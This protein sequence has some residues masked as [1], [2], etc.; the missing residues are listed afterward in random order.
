M[1]RGT[2]AFKVAESPDDFKLAAEEFKKASDV[3]PWWPEAYFNLGLVKEQQKEYEKAIFDLKLYLLAAPQGPD[4][5]S[6]KQK[7][8]EME[9]LADREKTKSSEAQGQKAKLQSLLGDWKLEI[10]L[11]QLH[12]YGT[13]T[14]MTMKDETTVEGYATVTSFQNTGYPVNYVSE[15]HSQLTLRGTLK[16]ESIQWEAWVDPIYPEC[17]SWQGFK[18]ITLSISGD[19]RRISFQNPVVAFYPSPRNECADQLWDYVLTRS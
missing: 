15:L 17:K 13:F 12:Q 7:I 10:Q 6:V 3:A 14:I 1:G 9:F 16:G 5:K 4:A 11:D 19:Q 18:Q 8:Y 2:A